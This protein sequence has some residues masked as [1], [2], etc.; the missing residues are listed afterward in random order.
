MCR[1]CVTLASGCRYA[2]A[3]A[4]PAPVPYLYFVSKNDGTHA[5]A[6]TYPEHQANVERW[7]RQYFRDQR[8]EERKAREA[9]R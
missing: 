1:S 3:A 2:D 8:A 7:Q 9:G 4:S 6:T 5:F